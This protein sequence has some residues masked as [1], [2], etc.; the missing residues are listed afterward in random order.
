MPDGY[1]LVLGGLFLSSLSNLYCAINV[2]IHRKRFGIKYPALYATKDHISKECKEAD[3]ETFNCA[4]RAHQNT[5][6]SIYGV[7]LQG[8]VLGFL[9]PQF[10]AGCLAVYALGRVL[11][12]NGYTAKGPDG[13]MLGGM[14]SH[15]GDLPLLLGTGYYAFQLATK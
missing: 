2:S 4:Q 1:G 10:A 6:E 11:Y 15:L 12:C 14:V 7:Q 5:L 8:A 13:R 3:V 9:N